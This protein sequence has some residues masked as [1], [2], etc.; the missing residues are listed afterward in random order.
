MSHECHIKNYSNKTKNGV[1]VCGC[2]LQSS[3]KK[4][5]IIVAIRLT[6]FNFH[7]LLRIH[8]N[9]LANCT[10]INTFQLNK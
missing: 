9:C 2:N 10:T 7:R 5:E 6:A 3:K 1:I 8:R 4:M